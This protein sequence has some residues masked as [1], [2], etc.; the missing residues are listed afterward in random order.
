MEDGL[1]DGGAGGAAGALAGAGIGAAGAAAF[2]GGLGAP[3]GALIGAAIGFFGGAGIGAVIPVEGARTVI[4]FI[5]PSDEFGLDGELGKK[6]VFSTGDIGKASVSLD[7][8]QR[9]DALA[10]NGLELQKKYVVRLRSVCLSSKAPK[11]KEGAEYYMLV[12][13]YGEEKPL[14]I[15]LPRI[16]KDA[17]VPLEDILVLK[18]CGGES[19]IEIRRKNIGKDVLV[20]KAKQGMTNG[21]SWVFIGKSSDDNGSFVEF[22]TFPAGD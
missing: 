9:R 2:T 7:G 1:G 5:L 13:L 12:T 19:A 16:P 22:D 6:I 15:D 21:T 8:R 18:N 17:I 4:S 10:Q 14:R 20:F 11:F 3:A